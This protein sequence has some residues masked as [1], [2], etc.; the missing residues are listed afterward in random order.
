MNKTMKGLSRRSTNYPLF[1]DRQYQP[2]PVVQ[3]N[4]NLYK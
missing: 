3:K 4:I 1:S 2:K